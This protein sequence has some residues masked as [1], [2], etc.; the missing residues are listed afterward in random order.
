MSLQSA[1]AGYETGKV[2]F[3]SLLEAQRQTRRARL[4]LLKTQVDAQ[5]RAA[6]IE[7][8]LGDAL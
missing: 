8:I 3:T 5:M 7:R 2:D 4:D 1:L 6:E